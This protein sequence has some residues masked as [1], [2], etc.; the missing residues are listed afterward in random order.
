MHET[1]ARGGT[2]MDKDQLVQAEAFTN[3]LLADLLQQGLLLLESIECCLLR[4]YRLN[5]QRHA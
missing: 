4:Y 2:K 3:E 5:L 1:M